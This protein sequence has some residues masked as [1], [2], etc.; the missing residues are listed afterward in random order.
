MDEK[1]S[2]KLNIDGHYY[3]I[4]VDRADEER[5]RRAATLI[6]DR[7]KVYKSKFDTTT[8]TPLDFVAMAAIEFVS[9]YIGN[10]AKTDDTELLSELRIMSNDINDYI[11]RINAL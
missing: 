1:L 2:I 9:K 3:S 5:F 10:E 4:R 11:Q 8:K 6:N 7:I